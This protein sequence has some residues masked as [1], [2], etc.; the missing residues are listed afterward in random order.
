[1]K[2]CSASGALLDAFSF[3][4]GEELPGFAERL[5]SARLISD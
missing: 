5:L 4:F 1:L 3:S 2:V